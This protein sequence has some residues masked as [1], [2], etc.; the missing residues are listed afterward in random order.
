MT[1]SQSVI[2]RR[3]AAEGYTLG[4]VTA[5]IVAVIN[6][7]DRKIMDQIRQCEQ[8]LDDAAAKVAALPTLAED[9]TTAEWQW[10]A[11]CAASAQYLKLEEEIEEK[12]LGLEYTFGCLPRG[13]RDMVAAK[14]GVVCNNTFHHAFD[15]AWNM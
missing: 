11:Y 10:E 6:E 3:I 1:I 8:K 14:L 13:V 9:T 4:Q 15:L 7:S 5:A 12:I 2:E